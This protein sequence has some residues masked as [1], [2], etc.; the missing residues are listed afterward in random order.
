MNEMLIM[1]VDPKNI[2]SQKKVPAN[3]E[4]DVCVYFKV[5]N[6]LGMF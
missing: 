5:K 4:K 3:L 2:F 6:K 1:Y